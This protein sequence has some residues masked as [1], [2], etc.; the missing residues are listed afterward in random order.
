M[1]TIDVKICPF[2][3]GLFHTCGKEF[4]NLDF[5]LEILS[6]VLLDNAVIKVPVKCS[7]SPKLNAELFQQ[8]SAI[9]F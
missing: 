7:N 6:I 2:F 9:F 3:S 8:A 5:F 4:S 1:L